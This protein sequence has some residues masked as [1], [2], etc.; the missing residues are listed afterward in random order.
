MKETDRI[1]RLMNALYNGEP[2]IDVNILDTLSAIDPTNAAKQIA[3]ER[4]SIWQTVNH[5]ISWRQTVLQRLQGELATTP[6]DN[7]MRDVKD[8]S[9]AAWQQTLQQ[10]EETQQQWNSFLNNTDDTGLDKKYPA[11]P[12]D[13]Y[14]II[15]GIIQHDAYHLGQIVLLTKLL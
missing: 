14:D 12:Y 6:D 10:L 5:L 8:T 2:W 13:H 11:S 15:H 7:Y 3:P 9:D 4:N 1:Q